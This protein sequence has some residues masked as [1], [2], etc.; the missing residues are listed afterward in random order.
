VYKNGKVKE[1]LNYMHANPVVR[2][3]V[4]HPREWPWSSWGD[5]MLGEKDWVGLI[6]GSIEES[7]QGKI[8]GQLQSQKNVNPKPRL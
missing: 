6:R 2:K 3:L 5:Y 7:I 8:Q 4:K 1:K